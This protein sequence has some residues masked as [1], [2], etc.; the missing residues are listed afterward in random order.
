MA[1]WLTC[2]SRDR[3]P[4]RI[5]TS[6]A[7]AFRCA[8]ACFPERQIY[9]RSE[10][11][12]QFY[13]VGRGLQVAIACLSVVFLGWVTFSTVKVVFKDWII[14]AKDHRFQQ[15]QAAFESQIADLQISYDDL[16]IRATNIRANADHRVAVFQRRE[17]A[18]APESGVDGMGSRRS[19][20]VA[21]IETG[22]ESR[23]GGK[24]FS[25]LSRVVNWLGPEHA[26]THLQIHN[27]ALDALI[28]DTASLARL[29]GGSTRIMMA[30][31]G[32]TAQSV[33]SEKKLIAGTGINAD[34]F[35]R[36]LENV[37]GVGG[38]EIPLDAIQLDG[39]SD[40][41]FSQAYFKAQA[42]IGEIADLRRAVIRL[43]TAAPLGSPVELTSGFGPRRDP[44][45]GRYAFHPGVDFSG[46]A[47][48][49]VLA[50][51][52]GLV[53]FAG[54]NGDYGNM[55]EI[56]HGFG[57][58][59]R[60]AHLLS[61]LV[62]KGQPVVKGTVVGQLGSTGR[63]TGPH[64]HYEVWY[65]DKVRDPDGFLRVGRL[66]SNNSCLVIACST[67]QR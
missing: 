18:L 39:V 20:P 4:G 8:A 47:G 44:F 25:L 55:V 56:D 43:P 35:L 3:R 41:A 54:F 14:A 46:P 31:E 60:Y 36:K 11:R 67:P 33:D 42:N 12:V 52:K 61:L 64:V 7:S 66:A 15:V 5:K 23:S 34:Q 17:Q 19:A 29:S 21:G 49:A 10:G 63:S 26:T 2:Q 28:A 1:R 37:E 9:V 16:V 65:D 45:S 62:A 38:P 32:R 24:T 22:S 48:T 59:T 27:S 51:A 57:L 40:R 58:K 30:V 50:T 53:T 13:T 6:V